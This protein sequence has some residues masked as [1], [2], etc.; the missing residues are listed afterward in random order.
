MRTNRKEQLG[1]RIKQLRLEKRIPQKDLAESIGISPS[2][3][4]MYEQNRRVPDADTLI[5][6]STYFGVTID[7][8]LGKTEQKEKPTKEDGELSERDKQLIDLISALPD[9]KLQQ[10]LDF[11]KYLLE[12][13]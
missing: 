6:L 1:N 7:Y 10:V 11:A 3:I 12:Q 8:L 13:K 9:D 2:T 5:K 4:G